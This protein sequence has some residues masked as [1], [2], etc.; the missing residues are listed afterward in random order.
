MNKIAI[1]GAG[2]AGMTAA[3]A[4]ARTAEEKK[5][6][7]EI[8]LLEHNDLPGRKILSTGNGRCNL[9]NE[10]MGLSHFHSQELQKAAVVLN[11][12]GLEET[13]AFFH[14]LGLQTKSRNGY[15][16]PQSDQAA[17]VRAL[18]ELELMRRRIP[19]HSGIH[20]DEIQKTED[21]FVISGSGKQFLADRVILATGGRAAAA[22]GSDGSGYK[23]ARSLGHS[24]LPV[25]PALVQLKAKPHPLSKASGVRVEGKVTAICGGSEM[26]SDQGELQI[27]SYG[28]SGIPVFQISRYIA[29]TLVQGEPAQVVVDLVPW[30]EEEEFCSFLKKRAEGREAVAAGDFLIGIFPEKLIPALLSIARIKKDLP[31]GELEPEA[32]PRLARICKSV[33]LKISDTNGFDNAQVCAGGIPLAEVNETTLESRCVNGLYLAGE[34]LDVDGECGGYNLQ[35]AWSSGYLAGLHAAQL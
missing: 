25:A 2:A 29:L 27:T 24:L 4:A 22:L 13:L 7:C 20:V 15:V 33:F 12:F 23:L 10:K 19:V 8:F 18:M 1:I 14:G 3:I 9:T 30:M 11:A 16:Y 21:G 31:V 17:A 32:F 35:W 26:A 5:N 6:P 28:I 34:I